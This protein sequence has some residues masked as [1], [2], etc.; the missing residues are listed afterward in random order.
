LSHQEIK[1]NRIV[2][3]YLFYQL[4]GEKSFV[5]LRYP[6]VEVRVRSPQA[7]YGSIGLVDSGSDRTFVQK[8]EAVLL[9]L[10]PLM[11]GDKPR[12]ETAIGAGG[13]LTCNLMTLPELQLMKHG[14]P[15]C[16]FRGLTVWVP[17]IESAIPYSII[18][19]DTAFKRFRITFDEGRR[20]II[21][22]R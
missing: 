14:R 1:D 20:Q 4:R 12:K 2:C 6:L 21:F 15:F 19:R 16:S 5:W 18:G 11:N 22:N 3:D 8:E 13:E 17:D 7:E 10:K 9:G